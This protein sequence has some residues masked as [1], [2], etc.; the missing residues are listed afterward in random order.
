MNMRLLT[1]NLRYDNPADGINAWE[2]R[3]EAV[4]TLIRNYE[5]DILC[6]QECMQSQK[7]YLESA[8]PEYG[9]VGVGRSDGWLGGE[10]VNIFYRTA[11]FEKQANGDFWLSETPDVIGSTSW[12]SALPRLASWIRLYDRVAGKVFYV[13]NTHF[14]HQSGQA[15]R[16]SAKLLIRKMTEIAGEHT[17]FLTGDLNLTLSDSTYTFLA[18]QCT[19]L[20]ICLPALPTERTTFNG[21]GSAGV[22]GLWIDYVF[23]TQPEAF[24]IHAYKV[25]QDKING[26]FPSDHFPIW[27]D[28]EFL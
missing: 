13:F 3:K 15:R 28:F 1:Y 4:A 27:V 10:M 24:K 9:L 16:E 2:N 8:F 18:S 20:R 22:A 19:D 23:S 5:V 6:V 21:F 7:D 12:E 11:R 17:A 25:I 14:D 26:R